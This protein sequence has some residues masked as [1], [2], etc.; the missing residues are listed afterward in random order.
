MK[1]LWVFAIGALAMTFAA[2]SSDNTT[3]NTVKDETAPKIVST[4]PAADTTIVVADSTIIITYDEKIYRTPVTTISINGTYVD[5][6]V[7]GNKLMFTYKLTGNTTYTVKIA[8]PSV[9]DSLYNFASTYSF[10]FKTFAV[11]NFPKDSFTIAENLVTENPMQQTVNLYNFLKE[12]FGSKVISGAMANVSYNTEGADTIYKMTGKY[13]A[14]NCFDFIHF[15][16]S[17][18]LNQESWAPD[19][20]NDSIAKAWWNA[21]GIVSYMWHWNVPVSKLFKNN[22]NKY[23]CS[24]NNTNGQNTDFNAANVPISGT[25]ENTIANRDLEIIA[26]YLLNL[27]NDGIPVIWRPLHEASG[28]ICQYSGGKAWFWWGNAGSNAFKALWKYMFDYFK[29]KGVKNLIWV[30][31]SNTKDADWYPG[32]EYVDI[33]AR[34]YYENDA[35]LY[36]KSIYEEMVALMKISKNKIITLG[37]CGAVPDIDNMYQGGD[38]WSWFMPWY[39]DYTTNQTYNSTTFFKKMLDSE[40]VIT[41]DEVP[42]LK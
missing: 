1:K 3:D 9:R 15:I 42:S 19:Y 39:G 28:N 13:P 25:Y 33:I 7:K 20:S 4:F 40:Y 14:I 38:M 31:T 12:N 24:V 36:H 21:G 37:E 23:T 8:K 30:W 22:Y 16:H 34:D 18:P 6:V 2:C 26:D 41:R 29:N 17:A 5:P 11:N 27:Q 35:S 32:D 10:S